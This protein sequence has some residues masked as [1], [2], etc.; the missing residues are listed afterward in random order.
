M[1]LIKSNK[2]RLPI[3][4]SLM[5]QE[6]FFTDLLNT[7]GGLLNFDRIFS[8]ELQDKLEV[9]RIN[10]KDQPKK[11]ELEL[12]VPGLSKEDFDITLNDGI[13]TISS[14]KEQNKEEEQDRYLRK[15]FSYK[16]F[17]RSFSLPDTIDEGKDVKATYKDGILKL[18][19]NKKE[20]LKPKTP[21]SVKV[22]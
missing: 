18:V 12:A 6:P 22:L 20:N 5:D 21:K 13:L 7:P 10:V 2:R 14:E 19:L 16:S 8:R 9:P 11:M 17:S 3:G 4:E 15:E 1:S